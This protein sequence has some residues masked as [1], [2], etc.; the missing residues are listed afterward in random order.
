M[1]NIYSPKYEARPLKVKEPPFG[2]H[3]NL[4]Y[5]IDEISLTPA[6]ANRHTSPRRITQKFSNCHYSFVRSSKTDR[7]LW[8]KLSSLRRFRIRVCGKT[9]R[10][11]LF[12]QPAMK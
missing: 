8:L 11:E 7:R 3:A 12:A 9:L 4:T 5:Q 2:P 6:G 10:D 1:L